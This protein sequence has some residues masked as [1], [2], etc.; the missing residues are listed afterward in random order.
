MIGNR[1]T[2]ID[3]V[4]EPGLDRRKSEVMLNGDEGLD[5]ITDANLLSRRNQ[6]EGVPVFIINGKTPLSGAQ[7][8]ATFLKAFE[9]AVAE[10]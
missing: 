1:H 2:L 3:V 10:T 6:V 5:A 8:P 4:A 7:Q 9:Q